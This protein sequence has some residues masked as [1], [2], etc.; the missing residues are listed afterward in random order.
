MSFLPCLEKKI[1]I[2]FEL[3]NP[4]VLSFAILIIEIV[5]IGNFFLSSF[6]NDLFFFP[7]KLKNWKKKTLDQNKNYRESGVSHVYLACFIFCSF[8]FSFGFFLFYNFKSNSIW[9]KNSIA[10][11]KKSWKWKKKTPTALLLYIS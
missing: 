2:I 9:Q 7:F 11:G 1:I 3:R 10:K 8:I 5:T 4:L 6:F